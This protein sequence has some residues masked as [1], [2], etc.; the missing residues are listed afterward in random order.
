MGDVPQL[1]ALLGVLGAL[2][3]MLSAI[4]INKQIEGKT[5]LG[6]WLQRSQAVVF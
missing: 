6:S 4:R 1:W 2:G 5:D 3:W